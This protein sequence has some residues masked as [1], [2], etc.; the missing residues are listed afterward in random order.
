MK[1]TNFFAYA[2][3]FI[4]TA[5]LLY[6]FDVIE[7]S[8]S[9]VI[10]TVSFLLGLIWMKKAMVHPERRGF[11]GGTFWILLGILVLLMQNFI[12]P[13]NDVFAFGMIF[14]ILAVANLI[15]HF[16]T[17]QNTNGNLASAL[18]FTAI[19]SLL[20]AMYYNYL[21]GWRLVDLVSVYWPLLLVGG[22]AY[23]I[24]EAFRRNRQ[25]R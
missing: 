13:T 9:E 18:V 14:L 5:L 15:A 1:Q 23:M 4:G 22:G 16:T 25:L 24:I 6:Q 11:L 3:I 17:I 2:L 12:L 21:S 10:I 7:F 19:G 20:L 8:R